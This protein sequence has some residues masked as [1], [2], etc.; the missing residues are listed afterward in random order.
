MAAALGVGLSFC[1]ESACDAKL[2]AGTVLCIAYSVC[3]CVCTIRNSCNKYVFIYSPIDAH[4]HMLLD[5]Q[6]ASGRVYDVQT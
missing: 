5:V 2:G 1:I 3:V 4:T 6:S